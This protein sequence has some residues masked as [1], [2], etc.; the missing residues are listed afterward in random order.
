MKH[1]PQEAPTNHQKTPSSTPYQTATP[2]AVVH[3]R[4][5]THTFLPAHWRHLL[6]PSTFVTEHC[7]Q[8]LLPQGPHAGSILPSTSISIS[9]APESEPGRSIPHSS[10]AVASLLAIGCAAGVAFGA[11]GIVQKLCSDLCAPPCA[12]PPSTAIPSVEYSPWWCAGAAAPDCL[13]A[14]YSSP[15]VRPG[16]A[17]ELPSR[18]WARHS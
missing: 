11:D 2:G 6:I 8:T 18:W 7:P 16:N 14:E 9:I 3:P 17:R 10:H 13:C 1:T 5:P 4:P 15:R 12:A